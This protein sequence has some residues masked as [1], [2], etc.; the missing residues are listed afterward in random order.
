MQQ[1]NIAGIGRGLPNWMTT[2]TSASIPLWIKPT[3]HKQGKRW[4]VDHQCGGRE[5]KTW[6]KA[7]NYALAPTE[8]VWENGVCPNAGHLCNCPGY[9]QPKRVW[10]IKGRDAWTTP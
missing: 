2:S 10:R 1:A 5:F 9:C 4:K 8:L 3:I 7:K 6:K